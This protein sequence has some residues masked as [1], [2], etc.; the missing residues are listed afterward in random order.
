MLFII[1]TLMFV[2]LSF[3][4]AAAYTSMGRLL[5]ECNDNEFNFDE[6]SSGGIY[7]SLMQV[8]LSQRISVLFSQD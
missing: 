6:G 3:S 2:V 4:E 5:Y 8:V 7:H 1:V